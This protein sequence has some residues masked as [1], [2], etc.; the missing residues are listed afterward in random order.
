MT[1]ISDDGAFGGPV[2]VAREQAQELVTG[3]HEVTILAAGPQAREYEENGVL[4]RLFKANRLFARSGFAFVSAPGLWLAAWR[5]RRFWDVAHIHLARD[6][7]T[8]PTARV[9]RMLRVPIVA[10]TH[11]MIRARSDWAA[12]V[13]DA[14]FTRPLLEKSSTVFALTDDEDDELRRVAPRARVTR[15]KNGVR[16]GDLPPSHT[17]RSLVLFLARLHPRKRPTHFVRMAQLLAP[18]FPQHEFLLAGADEGEG[19]AVRAAISDAGSGV[20]ISWIGPVPPSQTADLMASAQVYVLPSVN[21]VFPMTILEAF[22]VGTPTVATSSLG[23]AD[24]CQKHG[25]ALITDGSP[26]EL[27]AGV[28]S[29]LTND[30]LRSRLS[31]GGYELL[32]D[33]LDIAAVTRQLVA[34]YEAA[35][36]I[37]DERRRKE[38]S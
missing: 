21:E 19:A 33:E 11:G 8:L 30:D 2:T 3:G 4:Y 35:R 10:Q 12:R 14:L 20:D 31:A 22:R 13:L 37:V 25:A 34:E 7:V 5:S 26:E 38:P 15:I 36:M 24:L 27:A 32:R 1:Y 18:K 28:E 9:F 6:L 17:R 16:I 23:V 29:L